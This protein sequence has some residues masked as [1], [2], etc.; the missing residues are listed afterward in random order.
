MRQLLELMLEHFLVEVLEPTHDG[1]VRAFDD[2]VIQDGSSFALNNALAAVYPGRFTNVKPAAVELHATLS[3]SHDQII[4]VSLAADTAPERDFLPA[5]KTLENKLLLAD[6]GYGDLVYCDAV[7]A[8]GGHFIIRGKTNLNPTIVE[9]RVGARRK[10]KLAGTKLKSA[11]P[12]LIG[13][14][15]DLTVEWLR[16]GRLTRMRLVL[17]WNPDRKSHVILLTNLDYDRFSVSAVAALYRLRWQV[18][19]LFKEWKSY[20]NLH[21]FQTRNPNIAEG[22]IWASLCAAVL[23]RILAHAAQRVVGVAISTRTASMA[24]AY[25]LP[26]LV[27]AL[28]QGHRVNDAVSR[29]LLYLGRNAQRASP[30]RD[31]ERGRLRTGLAPVVVGAGA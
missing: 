7:A 27:Q 25:A 30:S 26:A 16:K 2:I 31:H 20:A 15:A 18:E 6:R 4:E 8:A 11:W 10:A 22:L 13:R 17:L 24:M 29:L 19:L 28:R 12:K 23:K 14:N 5:P 1:L 9:A 3:L 21:R